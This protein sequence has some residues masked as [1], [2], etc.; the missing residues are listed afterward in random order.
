MILKSVMSFD[1]LFLFVFKCYHLYDIY[2]K[3]ILLRVMVM[4]KDFFTEKYGNYLSQL[5]SI[6]HFLFG[7]LFKTV[8][9]YY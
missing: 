1:Q 7:D 6:W 8:L 9:N 5:N 3:Q 4:R 2:R